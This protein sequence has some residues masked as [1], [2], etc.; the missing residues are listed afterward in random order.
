MCGRFT[1]ATKTQTIAE[2]FGI[3]LSYELWP[4]YNIAPSQDVLVIKESRNFKPEF[5][6]MRWGLVPAWQKEEEISTQWIN[7][8]S[9]TINEKPLFKKLFLHKRCLIV[10]DGFYEWQTTSKGKRPYYIYKSNHQPFAIAGL[11]EHWEGNKGESIDS[12][13]LLTTDANPEVK[14][15]HH[16]MPVILQQSQYSAWLNPENTKIE[17]LKSFLQPYLPEDLTSH[18]IGTYVNSPKNDNE[19][20]IVKVPDNFQN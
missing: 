10:A 16:R 9:E 19:Q 1:L 12:C 5:S 2:Y 20:C 4:R 6:I 13:L 7:A 3:E 8:R 18:E 17:M 14:N 15:I 11:W